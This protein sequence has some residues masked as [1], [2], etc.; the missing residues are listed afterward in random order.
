M[1]RSHPQIT[2]QNGAVLFVAMIFLVLLTLLGLT[3]AGT[4]VLQER[5]TGGLRNAQ[6]GLM[7]AESAVRGVEALLWNK[8]ANSSSNKLHCG[9][10]GGDDFCYQVS[11]ILGAGTSSSFDTRVK[12]FRTL[13]GWPASTSG[14]GA[15]P[16]A[17]KTMTSLSGSQA[18][19]SL[20]QQPRYLIEDLGIL[21]APGVNPSCTGGSRAQ[22]DSQTAG[23]LTLHLYRIT[24]R[25]TG[26]STG[27]VATVESYFSAVPPSN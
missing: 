2:R 6:L 16:Y 11:N 5:M 15:A 1:H 20:A 27:S 12:T 3:A 26:G 13:R 14:D 24:A 25:A 7:G 21:L 22:C 19:A 4:S 10:T 8:S 23:N 17:T 18:T 9:A